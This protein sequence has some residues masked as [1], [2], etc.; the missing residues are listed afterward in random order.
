[1]TTPVAESLVPSVTCAR[2]G[3]GTT[4]GAPRCRDCGSPAGPPRATTDDDVPAGLR[5]TRG[6]PAG[7]VVLGRAVDALTVVASAASGS[8]ALVL[9]D[10][11]LSGD[12]ALRSA[13]LGGVVGAL[14]AACVVLTSWS[15][16]GR[17]LG[18]LVARTREVDAAD[19]LPLPLRRLPTRLAAPRPSGRVAS[20]QGPFARSLG[21]VVT[22]LV[23]GRDPSAVVAST[24][25]G[26]V[27]AS[28]GDLLVDPHDV[29]S[30][31]LGD[32]ERTLS[33]AALDAR[34]PRTDPAAPPASD[35]AAASSGEVLL[36]FRSGLVHVF[37]GAAVIGRGPAAPPGAVPLAVP[38]LSRTLSK[39]HA[40]LARR[41]AVVVLSDLGSTN[42]T[43]VQ[44]ADGGLAP[45]SP[46]TEA[47]LRPG[48]V[49]RIGD[50]EF[51]LEFTADA[52]AAEE[53][54]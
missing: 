6:A 32:L 23:T 35:A 53:R 5:G 10:V 42:G 34:R 52:P 37:S 54:R 15:R 12:G 19:G 11:A 39:S 17:A 31:D 36:R 3:A 41:G 44:T 2:C 22:D 1:M 18:G 27:R 46:G 49:V 13:V 21:T 25:R 43:T 9:L 24:S 26:P 8:G 48:A 29:V 16:R 47:E 20:G 51:T 33:A 50:H 4:P 28:T 45:L 38:D 7:R 40:S 30:D 14:A